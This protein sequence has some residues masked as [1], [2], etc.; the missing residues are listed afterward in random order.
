MRLDTLTRP[1]LIFPHLEASDGP[2]VLRQLA[3]RLVENDRLEIDAEAL[4]RKLSEREELGSTALGSGVAVPHCKL[5]GIDRVILALG[6]LDRGIDFGADDGE[7]VRLFFLV[8]SPDGAPAEH[9][10]SLAAISRWLKNESHLKRL[11]ELGD[12]AEI[13]DLLGREGG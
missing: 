10:R 11:F 6:L 1:E 3:S 13:Y 12:A 8:V 5:R 9:L 7:P 4:Y 2:E